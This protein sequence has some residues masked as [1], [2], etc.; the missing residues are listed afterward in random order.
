MHQLLE[1]LLASGPVI[2]DG[3][4]GTELQARGLRPGESPDAWNLDRPA[5]VADIARAY[6]DAGS[7]VV[8]TNTFGANRI[9]LRRFGLESH[10]ADVNRR[11]VELSREGAAGNAL[12]FA[13]MG[14]SGALMLNGET[15]EEE[16]RQVFGEQAEALA[17]AGADAIVVETMSDLREAAIAV[18]AAHATGLPVVGCM[19]FDSGRAKDRT[20]MG[21]TPE[22]AAKGLAEAGADVI[23]AN[24]GQ[25]IESYVTLCDRLKR[26]TNLPI[27]IKPNAG[28]PDVVAGQTVY[29]DT[30]LHFAS[31]IAPLRSVGASFIGGC[32]GTNPEYIRAIHD[33]LHHR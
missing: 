28:S 21:V 22:V 31:C 5:M 30:P 32:C 11:G 19:S 1:R 15:T 29:R 2:L 16:L 9:A 10:H 14:P 25:G 24:C 7:A 12:V 8:L 4:W 3:A 33:A 13:S 27:W 6:V 20:M 23:G 17:S 18:A 26:S